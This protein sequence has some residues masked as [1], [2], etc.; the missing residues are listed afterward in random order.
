MWT[1]EVFGGIV[2]ATTTLQTS[3]RNRR[4]APLI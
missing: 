3:A 4:H 1:L 2:N